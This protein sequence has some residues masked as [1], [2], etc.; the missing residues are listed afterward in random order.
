MRVIY[1]HSYRNRFLT[2]NGKTLKNPDPTS[3]S[4]KFQNCSTTPSGRKVCGGERKKK[5]FK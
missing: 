3:N 1:F 5:D 2:H 4:A